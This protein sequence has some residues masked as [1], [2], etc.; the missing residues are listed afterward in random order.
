LANDQSAVAALT[1]LVN[2]KANA[3]DMATALAGKAALADLA[4]TAATK[5]A[6]LI[7]IQDAAGLLAAATVE[8]ALLEILTNKATVAEI[9]AG[10]NDTKFLTIKGALD[11]AADVALADAA[12]IA[13]DLA[14]GQNFT[15][16]LGGNRTLGSPSNA[17]PN[18]SGVIEIRQDGTG[19]RTLGY[20]VNW[21]FT[22]GIYPTLTTTA[23]RVDLLY[24]HVRTSSFIQASLNKDV[25]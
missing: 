3:S 24:Y 7:G 10:T 14:L 9:R 12:T 25:R 20:G 13:V 6:A 23:S 11:A 22:G 21:K 5:G 19:S 16:T 18:Q 15:V 17:K 4:S 2:A 8:A 1:T